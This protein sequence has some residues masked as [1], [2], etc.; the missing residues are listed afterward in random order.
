[1]AKGNGGTRSGPTG[2][3]NYTLMPSNDLL[4]R[5]AQSGELR[6][7]NDEM[8]GNILSSSIRESQLTERNDVYTEDELKAINAYSGVGYDAINAEAERPG[9]ESNRI[10]QYVSALESAIGKRKLDKDIVVFRGDKANGDG[11]RGGFVSTS[12]QPSIASIFSGYGSNLHAYRLPKG[13][14]YIYIAKEGE[15]EVLLPRGFDLMKYK[16]R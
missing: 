13:T 7:M 1:M 14:S 12:L 4:L 11:N 10:R 6:R 15:D 3:R 5:L 8:R 16:I 9:V 2:R